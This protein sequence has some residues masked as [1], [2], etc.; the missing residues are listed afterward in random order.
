VVAAGSDPNFNL[1][2]IDIEAQ[3]ATW[4]VKL[5]GLLL[6]GAISAV[7][8]FYRRRMRP[9]HCRESFSSFD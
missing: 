7:V 6:G 9:R 3:R 8:H 5:L 1:R 2:Q 4:Q